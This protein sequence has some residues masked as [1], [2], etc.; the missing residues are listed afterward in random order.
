MGLTLKEV[1][2]IENGR[3]LIECYYGYGLVTIKFFE[4]K[5][6]KTTEWSLKSKKKN[7]PNIIDAKRDGTKPFATRLTLEGRTTLP[8]C[9]VTPKENARF[10]WTELLEKGFN[11]TK[12]TL[13]KL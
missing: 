2:E 10:F 8:F 3:I 12:E 4:T 1:Y 9:W 6:K 7:N 13:K 11:P 5:N